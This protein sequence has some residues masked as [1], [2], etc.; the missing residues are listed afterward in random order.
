[1]VADATKPGWLSDWQAGRASILEAMER[2]DSRPGVEPEDLVG[3]WRG[4]SL[5]TGHPLDGLLEALGWYGKSVQAPDHVHPLLFRRPFGGVWPL[6]PSLMPAGLALSWPSFAR[7]PLVRLAFA[8]SSPLLQARGPG[9]SLSFRRFRGRRS[10]ALVYRKQPITDHLR[11]LDPDR[12]LGLMER[13][14]MDQPFFFLLTRVA[15]DRPSLAAR[16]QPGHPTT[17][18]HR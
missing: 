8:A 17:E 3:L 10:V 6:E 4:H 13:K 1:M 16:R 12:V 14:G 5:P 7:S 15:G 9:A 18:P 11:G 2:F